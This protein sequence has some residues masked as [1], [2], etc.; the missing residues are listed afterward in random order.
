MNDKIKFIYFDVGGVAV[1]DFSKTNKWDEMTKDLGVNEFNRKKFDVIFSEF[2]PEICVS[3]KTL[4]EFIDVVNNKLKLD[5]PKSYDMLDDF[6]NRFEPNTTIEPILQNLSKKYR[7]GLLTNM[8]PNMLDKIKARNILPKVEWDVI[9]DSSIVG[10][11]KP[12]DS[13]YEL[14]EN[15]SGTNPKNILF[16]ENTVTHI[17]AAKKRGWQT[18]LYDPSDVSGS[19]SELEK[20]L[21]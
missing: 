6:V 8:Y 5:I 3:R 4:E 14:A 7:L 10:H 18:L 11:R 1:L 2:E 21:S 17:D 19:N 12:Q 16:V 15:K 13:I 20:K 9:I